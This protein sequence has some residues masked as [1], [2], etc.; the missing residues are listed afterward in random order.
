M[1]VSH[2]I[3]L[4]AGNGKLPLLL[5]KNI[6]AHGHRL[7]AI[8]FHEE[9]RK[10]LE[11]YVD[12]IH[13]VN[14]GALGKTIDLL[15]QEKV[16]KA[17]LIGGVPKTHFF[18]R[19]KPDLRAIKVLISLPQRQ[20]DTILRAIAKEIESEGI[21][22]I[23]PLAFLT[24]YIAP[25][26]VW[27]K[28]LPTER[29]R[30]DL[31][32]GEKIARQIGRLDIGQTIVVKNEMVLAVEAI[33]GTDQAIRRGAKLGRGDV[34]VIKMVKPHQDMRLDIPVIGLRT[35][36]TLTKAGATA[37]AVKAGKTIVIDKEEVIKQANESNLCLLGI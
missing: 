14:I 26:G 31:V 24:K 20:D 28:R 4:I 10:D 6:R 9:T 32:F 13:W 30:R 33:E 16:K 11:N 36:S 29:E 7:M 19:A 18:S 37:L 3:G 22:I 21:K 8:A 34:L 1:P 17:V 12:R 25:R 35:I 15:L 27:T 5:A 2:H 23:N